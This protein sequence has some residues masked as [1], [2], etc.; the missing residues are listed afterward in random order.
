[1]EKYLDGATPYE[2]EQA[3]QWYND[4]QT[5]AYDVAAR[6]KVTLEIGACIVSSFSPRVPWSRN[7]VLALA[8]ADGG[9]TPGLSNSRRMADRSMVA[10]FDALK[11][12]KTNAF[13]RAIAGDEDAVVVD[14]WMCKAASIGSDRPS[15]VQ[16][17]RISDAIVTLARRHGVSPRTMQALIWIR[18]RGKAD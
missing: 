17:R 16:Y 5:V 12:P 2:W 7:V 1:M 3:A 10:G 18:V 8:Y 13:A 11:G 15:P 9:E 4:A 14:S 6:R